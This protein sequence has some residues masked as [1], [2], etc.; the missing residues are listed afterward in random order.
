MQ[1]VPSCAIF[2]LDDPH[3]RIKADLTRKISIGF[4]NGHRHGLEACKER[5]VR[6]MLFGKCGRRRR[7]VDVGGSVQTIDF[8]E[9]SPSLV[10]TAAAQR[11][12]YAFHHAAPQVDRHPHSGLEP[13]G[14]R[15]FATV[16]L[17]S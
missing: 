12:K 1:E 3:I 6:G 10:G 14:V 15:L 8:D 17:R 5:A 4:G 9:N 16:L 7:C 13:H 11:G 2:G